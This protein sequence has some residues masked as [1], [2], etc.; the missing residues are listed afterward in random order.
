M[1]AIRLVEYEARCR[2]AGITPP[3]IDKL[4][5]L[6]RASKSRKWLATKNVNNPVGQIVSCWVFENPQRPENIL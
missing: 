2:N 6:L 1:L 4:K 5:K 3:E